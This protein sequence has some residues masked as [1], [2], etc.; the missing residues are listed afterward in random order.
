MPRKYKP[1]PPMNLEMQ[2]ARLRENLRKYD[3]LWEDHGY[4]PDG[5]EDNVDPDSTLPENISDLER[6]Y[7]GI[8]WRAPPPEERVERPKEHEARKEENFRAGFTRDCYEMHTNVTVKGFAPRA[9]GKIYEYGRIQ[10]T[11]DKRYIGEEAEVQI[12]IRPTHMSEHE[13]TRLRRGWG[14]PESE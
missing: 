4:P 13:R 2:I 14:I 10:L 3:P 5:W 7:P 8:N 6:R 11:V 12:F 9:K 1:R